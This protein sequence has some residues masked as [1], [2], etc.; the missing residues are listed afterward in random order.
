M[1]S[2]WSLL[3]D[4]AR[5]AQVRPQHLFALVSGWLESDAVHRAPRK[6]FTLSPLRP[7][8]GQPD[9][10]VAVDVGVLDDALV[11]LLLAGARMVAERGGRLGGQSVRV[12]PWPDGNLGLLTHVHDWPEL[13]GAA[14]VGSRVRLALLSPT[15]FR[16]G[17]TYLPFPLPGLV[18][19]HLREVWTQWG[20]S[21]DGR[22]EL[23]LDDCRL[24][25][26]DFR[27][28]S[29]RVNL[30][31]RIA[32]GS[33]GEVTYR[34][35]AR[36]PQVRACLGRWLSVLPYGGMGAETRLGFG[37]VEVLNLDVDGDHHPASG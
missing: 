5:P 16:H 2:R 29:V 18:F 30:R 6:P 3:F 14:G 19:G 8:D 22:I 4:I 31:T 27:L 23:D 12:L 17:N 26:D 32:V 34:C 9:R 7:V 37:Q 25:V 33:V 21:G 28:E 35:G 10:H 13:A 11:P 24:A 20:P 1:P 36:S 15:T